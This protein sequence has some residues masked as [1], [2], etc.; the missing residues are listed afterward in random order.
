M[1]NQKRRTNQRPRCSQNR[2][3]KANTVAICLALNDFRTYVFKMPAATSASW[4]K[5]F[6]LSGAALSAHSPRHAPSGCAAVGYPLQSLPGHPASLKAW[7]CLFR[8]LKIKGPV[9]LGDS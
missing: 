7:C 2:G 3:F 6:P 8:K 1:D 4:P 9:T 5:R